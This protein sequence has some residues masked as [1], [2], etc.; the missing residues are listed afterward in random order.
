MRISCKGIKSRSCSNTLDTCGG[1]GVIDVAAVILAGGRGKRAGGAKVFLTVGG[2]CLILEV[3]E[4]ALSLFSQV[5]IS[6]RK[7]DSGPLGGIIQSLPQRDRV[8]TVS[9]RVEGLGPLE[10]MAMS[11]KAS[12]REWAFVMGCDM[13]LVDPAVV[14]LMWS[15]RG[16]DEDAVIARIGGFLE[17]LHAFYH[18]RCADAVERAISRSR[19]KIT[20]FL[21]DISTHVIEERELAHIPGYRRSFLNVNTP[22][23]IRSWLEERH[24][25]P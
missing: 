8:K 18:K 9:D 21:S 20:S 3:L 1:S 25:C 11:L 23:D 5:I 17:P 2:R 19:H 22:E 13:P 6:C 24:R 12:E 14:R 16:E 7:E 10:G 4:R 15:K